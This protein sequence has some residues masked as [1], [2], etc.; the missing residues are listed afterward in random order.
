MAMGWM[1]GFNSQQGQEIFV[2]TQHLDQLW[3]PP[4]P[5]TNGYQGLFRLG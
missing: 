1:A 4:S 2:F 5:L 3:G